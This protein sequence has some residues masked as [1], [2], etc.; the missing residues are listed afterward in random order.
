MLCPYCHHTNHLEIDMHSE[1]FSSSAM[2]ECADCGALLTLEKNTLDT[3]HGPTHAV[4]LAEDS[5]V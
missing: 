3:I 1:G 2:I 4:K 5:I